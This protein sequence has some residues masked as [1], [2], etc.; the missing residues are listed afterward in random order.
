MDDVPNA[1]IYL[2]LSFMQ[3]IYHQMI[4]LNLSC[5]TDWL[6]EKRF[7]LI[8]KKSKY[9]LFHT[10]QNDTSHVTSQLELNNDKIK[11]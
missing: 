2:R 9:M 11:K 3:M 6:I 4:N 10:Y 7:S 1:V 8:V 5:V